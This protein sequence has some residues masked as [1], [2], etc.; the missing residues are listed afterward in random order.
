MPNS[1]LAAAPLLGGYD[2]ETRAGRLRELTDLA[3]VCVSTPQ[4]GD[5]DMQAALKSAYG[6]VMPDNGQSVLSKDGSLRIIRFAPDQIFLAFDRSAPDAAAVVA[7][8]IGTAGYV[9]DQS[10]NWVALSLSGACARAALERLC[11]LNLH[12][13]KFAVDQAERTQMEHMGALVARSG[14][15]EFLLLS[16][17]SSA[18]TFLHALETSLKYVS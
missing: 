7:Q 16:A 4:G 12:R 11:A 14:E 13:D 5:Q 8:K 6:A 3:L 9:V 17:A 15:D 10:H 2:Q 1:P 18:A